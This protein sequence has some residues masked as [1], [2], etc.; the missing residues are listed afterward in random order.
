MNALAALV[1][2]V[3]A[4]AAALAD[5]IDRAAGF[6]STNVNVDVDPFCPFLLTM[7]L[8]LLTARFNVSFSRNNREAVAALVAPSN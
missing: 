4:A 3:R 2:C 7:V 6:V 5:P 8:C 1:I